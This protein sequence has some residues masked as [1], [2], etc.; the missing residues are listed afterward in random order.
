[1]PV[2]NDLRRLPR[3]LR[4][5]RR[6]HQRVRSG[7]DL[8]AP[9][10]GLSLLP[11]LLTTTLASIPPSASPPVPIPERQSA[12]PAIDWSRN[13]GFLVLDTEREIWG[14]CV[15]L[16]PDRRV[17]VEDNVRLLEEI[18]AA[19]EVRLGTP[20][21]PTTDPLD[22]LL[23][24]HELLAERGF[25]YRDYTSREYELLG[26]H[27]I[28]H[29]LA[30]RE[31]DCSTFVVLYL[32]IAERLDLPLAALSLPGHLALRW[33]DPDGESFNWEPTVPASCDD[34]FYRRWKDISPE[35]ERSGA[36]LR[37]LSR[38]EVVGLALYER[39]LTHHARGD[40]SEALAVASASISLAPRHPD[41]HNLRGLVLAERGDHEQAL[42]SFDHAIALDPSFAHA[43]FNRAGSRLAL[44]RVEEAGA[45]IAL[46]GALDREL[47]DRLARRMPPAQ[48]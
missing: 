6:L 37:P 43:Y 32:A 14:D 46:L 25:T 28:H 42:A 10:R 2:P 38:R 45:D 40:R 18:L 35:A 24:I 1:M 12:A 22:Q 7:R 36:Y 11:L 9:L 4:R 47:G 21:R 26:Y 5:L 33:I 23:T 31:I 48:R 17:T 19:A 39:G 15:L 44:G 3:P 16:T 41:G 20:P 27:L 13:I 30:R 8:D 29:G 34:G